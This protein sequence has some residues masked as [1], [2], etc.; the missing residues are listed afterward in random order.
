MKTLSLTMLF[1]F[2]VSLTWAQ[3]GAVTAAEV[4]LS[5]GK[6]DKAMEKFN[7]ALEHEYTKAWAKTYM[8]G[9]KLYTQHY[10]TSK[11]LADLDKAYTYLEQAVK[12]N[13]TGDIKGK[14]AGK[15]NDELKAAILNYKRDFFNGGINAFNNEDF[16]NAVKFFSRA[17]DLGKLGNFYT[18]EEWGIDTTIIYNTALAASRAQDHETAIKYFK[19]A[20]DYGYNGS[21]TY[22]LLAQEYKALED[23][24]GL[25]KTLEEGFTKYPQEEEGLLLELINHY[26]QTDKTDQALA[27]MEKALAKDNSNATLHF[28]QGVLLEK[29]DQ[30]DEAQKSYLKAIEIDPNHADAHFNL[31]VMEYNKATVVFNKATEIENFKAYQKA[32]AAA[33]LEFKKALPYISK[34][35]ELKPDNS[36][37]LFSLKQVYYRMG[38]VEKSEEIQK[39]I[40]NL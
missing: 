8:L 33:K 3:K 15:Y 2:S 6:V 29:K 38:E 1:L 24:E 22:A 9:T 25:I 17:V 11:N 31:G 19:K 14:Q 34:A 30:M 10:I 7:D 18:E 26:L 37:Y 13:E 12:Y 39:R 5:E 36:S 40:D 27:Y 21:M 28:A 23:N 4:F 35:V 20:A 32:L 16:N